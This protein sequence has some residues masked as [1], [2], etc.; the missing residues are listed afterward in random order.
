MLGMLGIAEDDI[1]ASSVPHAEVA[2]TTIDVTK[3][4]RIQ[5]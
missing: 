1:P 5:P 4:A 3:T 2:R